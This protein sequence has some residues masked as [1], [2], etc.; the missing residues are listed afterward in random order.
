MEGLSY[1][2]E[3][4][5]LIKFFHIQQREPQTSLFQLIECF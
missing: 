4:K 5:R 1:G 2:V 3:T